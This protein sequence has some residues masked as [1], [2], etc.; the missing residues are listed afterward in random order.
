[1][2]SAAAPLT[3]SACIENARERP[4]RRRKSFARGASGWLGANVLGIFLLSSR[5]DDNKFK[6]FYSFFC[7]FELGTQPNRRRNE[8]WRISLVAAAHKHRNTEA[9]RGAKKTPS[10][11]NKIQVLRSLFVRQSMGPAA[12]ANRRKAGECQCGQDGECGACIL[13]GYVRTCDRSGERA[14]CRNAE[15]AERQR[16]RERAVAKMWRCRCGVVVVDSLAEVDERRER[17]QRI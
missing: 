10:A 11:R 13:A 7:A 14:K 2:C 6:N 17:W 12:L 3:S 1:M 4:I 5:M 8:S 15:S 16:E 9:E